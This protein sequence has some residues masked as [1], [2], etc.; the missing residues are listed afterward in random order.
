MAFSLSQT[1][2]ES[3]HSL[4]KVYMQ[5]IHDCVYNQSHEITSSYSNIHC[6]LDSYLSELVLSKTALSDLDCA[7]IRVCQTSR[8][9][10]T[11]MSRTRT[12]F[13]PRGRAPNW[14]RVHAT[15][16][17]MGDVPKSSLG[18]PRGDLSVSPIRQSTEDAGR[19]PRKQSIAVFHNRP[20]M[21]WR[22]TVRGQTYTK[23]VR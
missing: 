12:G 13:S 23:K 1:I 4:L 18:I 20:C 22:K 14:L 11:F 9:P 2:R 21:P 17:D 19:L 7:L 6:H 15:L 8:A 16:V 10:W 5:I 3:H